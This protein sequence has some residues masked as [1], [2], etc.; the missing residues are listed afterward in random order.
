MMTCWYAD[1]GDYDGDD[2]DAGDADDA[3]DDDGDDDGDV[4]FSNTPRL[5][6]AIH[7]PSTDCTYF[8]VSS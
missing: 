8:R 6:R 5:S 7:R 3:D 1:N 4:F 2:D